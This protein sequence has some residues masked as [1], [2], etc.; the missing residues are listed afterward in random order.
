MYQ[1]TM[2]NETSQEQIYVESLIAA[3]SA[4]KQKSRRFAE[5]LG[6]EA[7]SLSPAEGR[8]LTFLIKQHSCYKFV[9][10]GTLTGLSAQYIL[11][12]LGPEGKLWS[13]EKSELH[14]EKASE[15]LAAHPLGTNAHLVVGDARLTLESLA[16]EGPF[17]GIFIDGNKGAYGDYLAWAE[18]NLRSGALL[19]ADNIFLSG[20]VWGESEGQAGRF[21]AKQVRV[22]QE[23]NRRLADPNLY[24]SVILPSREGLHVAI[25][26]F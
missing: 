20:A 22:M 15:A 25:K 23:F 12:G 19:I 8:V 7:I 17:D 2:R 5:E 4:S 21:S 18:K 14:A 3:E 1:W 26:K 11:E 6:L 24:E 16:S 9:E 10:I 13:L